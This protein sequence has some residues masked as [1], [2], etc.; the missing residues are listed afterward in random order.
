MAGLLHAFPPREDDRITLEMTLQ[1]TVTTYVAGVISSWTPSSSSSSANQVISSIYNRMLQSE[2]QAV[3]GR[4]RTLT[5]KY[6]TSSSTAA[7]DQETWHVQCLMEDATTILTASRVT[8]WDESDL[9]GNFEIIVK[10]AMQLRRMVGEDV[11]GSE[12]E[13]FVEEQKK[14]FRP[15]VMVDEHAPRRKRQDRVGRPVICALTLGLRRTER[16][17]RSGSRG[18]LEVKT[19][20]KPQVILDTIVDDL[21][22]VDDTE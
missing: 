19:L 11:A 10:A 2:P 6:A 15:E 1:T 14:P 7:K 8:S 3:A 17:N 16:D 21:G 20:V 9:R 18:R 5:R 13:V 22:L 12:Y 4:W